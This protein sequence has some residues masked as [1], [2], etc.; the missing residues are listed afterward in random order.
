M[1]RPWGQGKRRRIPSDMRERGGHIRTTVRPR[2]AQ[3]GQIGALTRP[4]SAPL[5][6][7]LQSLLHTLCHV[8][9][10]L[11]SFPSSSSP[12]NGPDEAY[13]ILPQAGP[14]TVQG[15]WVRGTCRAPAPEQGMTRGHGVTQKPGGSAELQGRGLSQPEPKAEVSHSGPC[16]GTSYPGAGPSMSPPHCGHLGD[17]RAGAGPPAPTWALSCPGH[18]PPLFASSFLY[19]GGLLLAQEATQFLRSA[20]AVFHWTHSWTRAHATGCG[21]QSQ[22]LLACV[23]PGPLLAQESR[24][25]PCLSRGCSGPPPRPR[26]PGPAKAEPAEQGLPCG[27]PGRALR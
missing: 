18:L 20:P 6:P 21:P 16:L 22:L 24:S 3:R 9:G 2:G 8:L 27:W 5:R 15:A 23:S 12:P 1:Q 14:S 11:S 17:V 19:L 13:R 10:Q 25:P 26:H 7:A 4:G